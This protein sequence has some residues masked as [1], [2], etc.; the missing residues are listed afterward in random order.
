MKINASRG[1]FLALIFSALVIG[2]FAVSGSTKLDQPW[3]A[4][5]NTGGKDGVWI[6]IDPAA[7]PPSRVLIV[8]GQFATVQMKP[9][10]PVLG[11][12][13]ANFGLRGDSTRLDL[14]E[15][16]SLAALDARPSQRLES[17]ELTKGGGAIQVSKAARHVGQ[18]GLTVDFVDTYLVSR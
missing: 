4:G 5:V 16:D 12:R 9:G 3:F 2:A 6:E 10:G 7:A 15:M 11:I 18:D 17:V 1:I 14:F 13:A 8:E